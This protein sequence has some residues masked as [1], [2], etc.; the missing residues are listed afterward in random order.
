MAANRTTSMD[1]PPVLAQLLGPMTPPVTQSPTSQMPPMRQAFNPAGMGMSAGLTTD[2]AMMPGY[3]EGGMVD[4]FSARLVTEDSGQDSGGGES[5]YAD[6][7]GNRLNMF[8]SGQEGG[9]TGF[10]VNSSGQQFIPSY[11]DSGMD[12]DQFGSPSSGI[13]SFTPVQ[14]MTSTPA[15]STEPS[16]DATPPP[17]LPDLPNTEGSYFNWSMAADPTSGGSLTN[18]AEGGMV[19]A[20]GVP[21]GGLGAP[22]MPQGGMPQMMGAGGG[23]VGLQKGGAKQPMNLQQV[24]MQ[25]KEFMQQNPQHVAQIQQVIQAGLQSGEITMEDL[26]MLEQLATTAMQNPEMYPYIRQ[27]AIQQGFAGEQ[28]LSPQYDEG[29]VITVLIATRA[30]KQGVGAPMGGAPMGMEPPSF[31][32]GGMVDDKTVRPGDMASE[33]GKV[34]GPGTGT[35]DSV[36]IRVSTGEY[37]IPANV[38]RMKGKEFFDSMLEKYKDT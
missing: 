14:P 8:E 11:Y 20:G 15:A 9:D 16:V 30:A 19:G 17:A 29:L 28:D 18:Y 5:Y 37:V 23:A 35:S 12:G 34:K 22:G 13:E 10:Y 2:N 36:P 21:V 32:L 1:L 26:N 24:E 4:P 31:A 7:N 33:G 6:Q 27:F 3:A 38:V 25:I